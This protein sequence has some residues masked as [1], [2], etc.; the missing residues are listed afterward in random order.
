MYPSGR[1]VVEAE[2]K[3]VVGTSVLVQ[4]MRTVVAEREAHLI[5][6]PVDSAGHQCVIPQMQPPWAAEPPR[7]LPPSRGIWSIVG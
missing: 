2:P 1:K 5:L 7:Q 3:G 6:T 4:Q